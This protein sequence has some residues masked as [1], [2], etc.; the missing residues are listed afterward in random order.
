M[1]T[2][3]TPDLVIPELTSETLYILNRYKD[4]DQLRINSKVPND[5]SDRRL[6]LQK[7][8]WPEMEHVRGAWQVALNKMWHMLVYDEATVVTL[9]DSQKLA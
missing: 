2:T 3:Q 6:C 8:R 1:C 4:F 9:G 5:K 7:P